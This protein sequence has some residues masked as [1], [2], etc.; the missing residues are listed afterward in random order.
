[1]SL[2]LAFRRFGRIYLRLAVTFYSCD[3]FVV[4]DLASLHK[5]PSLESVVLVQLRIAEN[6]DKIF[7]CILPDFDHL[8]DDSHWASYGDARLQRNQD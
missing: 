1:M 8:I 5:P 3:T 2:H 6:K 7:K 4:S